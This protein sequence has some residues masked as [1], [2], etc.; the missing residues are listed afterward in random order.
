MSYKDYLKIQE[1]YWNKRFK[2]EKFIWGKKT[3]ECS[4]DALRR[5][6]QYTNIHKILVLGAG[7]GRNTN[8]FQDHGYDVAC[9]E[10]SQNAINLAKELNPKTRF[11]KNSIMNMDE[12]NESFDAIFGFDIFHLFLNEERQ[13]FIDLCYKHLNNKGV[14]YLSV[15]S[16]ME[17]KF[18]KEE[19][20]P[21]TFPSRA[22]HFI[23]YFTEQDLINNLKKFHII[24]TGIICEHENHGE[25]GPHVHQMRYIFAQK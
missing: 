9:L 18:G 1:T 24:D 14:I 8:I 17:E 21:K 10:I 5:F 22:G 23:H 20:E 13:K 12:I 7:Y 6:Q 4:K 19:V 15:Y 11:Y 16:E 3:S 2:K 25:I